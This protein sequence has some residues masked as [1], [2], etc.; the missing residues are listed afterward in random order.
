MNT[1]IQIEYKG[2]SMSPFLKTGDIIFFSHPLEKEIRKGDIIAYR[3]TGDIIIHRVVE[4]SGTKK[5]IFMTKP[6]ASRVKDDGCLRGDEI[7]GKAVAIWRGKKVF[8]LERFPLI[9]TNRFFF[10]LSRL[11][12]IYFWRRVIRKAVSLFHQRYNSKTQPSP[13]DQHFFNR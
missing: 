7:V 2:D 3:S 11:N 10:C 9:I 5:R 12:L 6:D 4:I 1:L 13:W 8:K